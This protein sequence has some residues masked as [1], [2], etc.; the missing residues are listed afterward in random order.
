MT[1]KCWYAVDVL[2]TPEGSE[3]AESALGVAGAVGTQ[4]DG[5]RKSATE[6]V[7]VSAFF[8]QEIDTRLVEDAV[9][10]ELSLY[11]IDAASILS[12][13]TRIVE[14]TDWLAEWKKHWNPV[15]TG[16]FIVA[17]PWSDIGNEQGI[18]IRVEPNMA[19]GT[20]THETTQLCLSAIDRLY[21]SSMSFL[22]VGTGTGI[23]SIAAAKLG[24]T[25]VLGLDTDAASV[26]IARENAS[27]NDVDA[28]TEF[29]LGTLADVDGT[30]DFVCANLTL[31][32]IAPILTLLLKRAMSTLI[33]SGILVEQEAEILGQLRENGI[34]EPEVQR[35]GEWIAVT[36]NLDQASLQ[37]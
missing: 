28:A 25:K 24:G 3:A 4:I 33:L 26:D 9:R 18:V 32:V 31:D 27:A 20:G 23:L 12:V 16:R 14:E 29:L 17:P 36:V 37:S 2:V 10:S 8:E 34:G 35:K 1:S 15:R 13:S 7:C 6:P 11:G 19:F 5:L 30:F 22:D 21:A